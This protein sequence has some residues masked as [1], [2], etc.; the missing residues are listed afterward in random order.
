MEVR[1]PVHGLIRLY[2]E[3]IP[4]IKNDFFGRLRSI[5]QL[6]LSEYIFP[7][8]THSRFLHS[9]GVMHVG[10]LA[11]DRLFPEYKSSIDLIRL[12]ETFRLACLLHDIGHAPLSHS[13]EMAMPAV[14]ELNIPKEFFDGNKNHDRQ[15]THEDYTLKSMADSSF[16]SAFKLVEE[17]FGVDRKSIADLM[18]GYAR[19][20]KYFTVEGINYFPILHQLVSSELDCDRMDYLLRDSYFCGVSYGNFD[21]DWL[22][23]NLKKCVINDTAYLG[24]SERAVL[25]FEDFLLCRY[26]MF[27]M[28]YFH[29]RAVCLEQLLCKFFNTSEGEYVIPGDIEKYIE[30]D[31]HFL[32]KILRKSENPYAKA[33]V[34][35]IIPEKIFESYNSKQHKNLEVIEKYLLDQKIDY[36]KGSSEGRISK[37]YA[38]GRENYL[39]PM[40]VVRMLSGKDVA[41]YSDINEATDLFNKF[42]KAHS[43]MRLHCDLRQLKDS[44]KKELFDLIAHVN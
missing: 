24:I 40:K 21:L 12:R 41:Q 9:L 1:D 32:N 14:S 18:T 42:R 20:P 29:Y 15:A 10:S 27:V 34:K 35:N 16:S 17:K 37:Y 3:E 30:H 19:N 6:G 7:G 4:I 43:I 36:I 23:D 2:D 39:Y 25:T 44:Q 13:S 26:H 33:I 31:D 22:L 8:A 5:K 11:F 28:V 38:D